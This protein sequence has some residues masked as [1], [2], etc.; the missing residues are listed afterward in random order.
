LLSDK[1]DRKLL[2]TLI[3]ESFQTTIW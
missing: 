3:N 1:T 2:Q